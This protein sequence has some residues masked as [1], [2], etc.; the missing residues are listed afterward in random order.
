[1]SVPLNEPNKTDHRKRFSME[2]ALAWPSA[3]NCTLAFQALFLAIMSKVKLFS[4][5]GTCN[6]WHFRYLAMVPT[7]LLKPV[8]WKRNGKSYRAQSKN[9]WEES[10][11]QEV[12]T[13]MDWLMLLLMDWVYHKNQFINKYINL[14]RW[15]RKRYGY[16]CV[17]TIQL[18]AMTIQ[19]L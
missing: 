3:I 17:D 8:P 9:L 14:K 11:S 19:A 13:F 10:W 2:K 7:C 12:A 18:P 6:W 4:Y 5:P 16:E 1:M 15:K